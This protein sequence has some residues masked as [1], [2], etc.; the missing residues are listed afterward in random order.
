[1]SCTCIPGTWIALSHYF[2]TGVLLCI[3]YSRLPSLLYEILILWPPTFSFALT[4]LLGTATHFVWIKYTIFCKPQLCHK[5]LQYFCPFVCSPVRSEEAEQSLIWIH[6]AQ[7]NIVYVW[8]FHAAVEC[9]NYTMLVE[10][11]LGGKMC[12]CCH[13]NTVFFGLYKVLLMITGFKR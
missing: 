2:S 10:T 7:E 12:I 6:I 11:S 9:I 1:M 13:A 4:F 8:G 3:T 5:V